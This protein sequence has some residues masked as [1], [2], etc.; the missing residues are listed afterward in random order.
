MPLSALYLLAVQKI[1]CRG[2]MRARFGQTFLYEP[3]IF[4][5]TTHDG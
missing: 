4:L 1:A 5:F 2:V 3:K